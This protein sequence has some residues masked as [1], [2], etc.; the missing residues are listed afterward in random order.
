M[1]ITHLHLMPRL[2]NVWSHTS[3]PQ[4]VVMAW[5]LIK[6][7]SLDDRGTRV[8]F[9]AGPGNFSLHHRVQT[10]SEPTQS[11]I[12]WVPRDL[13][14][15]VKRPG[16]EADHSPPSSAEVKE[17]VELHIH[18]PDTPSWSGAQLKK[19]QGQ[20]YLTFFLLFRYHNPIKF[21]NLHRQ[22]QCSASGLHV[23]KLYKK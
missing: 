2:K 19:A 3:T 4:Y 18:S 11:P 16:Y 17:C 7:S 6:I 23:L 14:I 20:L 8:R 12:Q 22:I 5:S 21:I 10:G 13:S 15:G 9:P 1:L